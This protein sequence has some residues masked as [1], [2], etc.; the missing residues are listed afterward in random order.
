[1]LA[2]RPAALR[3]AAIAAAKIAGHLE[4]VRAHGVE[5]MVAG[6]A[7]VGVERGQQIETGRRAVDHRH[8]DRVIQR[9]HRVV[10]HPLQQ[11]VEREDLRPVGVGGPR[12]FVVDGGDR[13]LQLVGADRSF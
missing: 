13:R 8:G 11:S 2:V 1:M 4:Q 9:D 12:G 3:Y 7:A 5:T 10:G 6:E